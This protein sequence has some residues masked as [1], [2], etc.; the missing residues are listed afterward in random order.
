MAWMMI[1]MEYRM[2][3]ISVRQREG[4]VSVEDALSPAA[5]VS[6]LVKRC[7]NQGIVLLIS[8]LRVHIAWRASV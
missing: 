6:V 7:A 5:T 1:V 8:V 4:S 2:K 3:A